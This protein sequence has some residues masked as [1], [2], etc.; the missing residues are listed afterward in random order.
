MCPE[1]ILPGGTLTIVWSKCYQSRKEEE[2]RHFW[3]PSW[4]R[5]YFHVGLEGRGLDYDTVNGGEGWEV[6]RHGALAASRS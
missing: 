1:R 2:G 5:W 4:R 6:R 3:K